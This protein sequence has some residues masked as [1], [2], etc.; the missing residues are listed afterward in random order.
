MTY[1]FKIRPKKYTDFDLLF[2]NFLLRNWLY[3]A[4]FT[5]KNNI[6]ECLCSN[7]FGIFGMTGEMQLTILLSR[8]II[9][10]GKPQS[11]ISETS[12]LKIAE[13]TVPKL[14]QILFYLFADNIYC[15]MLN[16]ILRMCQHIR[17][18]KLSDLIVS[19]R[20]VINIQNKNFIQIQFIV[21]SVIKKKEYTVKINIMWII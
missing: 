4:T 15:G 20:L 12:L 16:H 18:D 21:F 11:K 5:F 6:L 9:W 1:I 8:T 2:W 13:Y 7:F 10:N 19:Y 17:R 14:L 3:F